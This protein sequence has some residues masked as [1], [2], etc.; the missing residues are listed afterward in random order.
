MAEFN[1]SIGTAVQSKPAMNDSLPMAKV[2]SV[3]SENST[4]GGP[5]VSP[6]GTKEGPAARNIDEVRVLKLNEWKEAALSLAKAFEKDDV[7]HSFDTCCIH[8]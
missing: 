5:A 1:G 3:M 8:C 6:N 2:D 7:S 4:T